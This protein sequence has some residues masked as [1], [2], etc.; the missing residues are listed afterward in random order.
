MASGEAMAT[1]RLSAEM[2]GLVLIRDL[3][4][5]SC[6]RAENVDALPAQHL[7]PD[8]KWSANRLNPA[9]LAKFIAEPH[10]T[11]PGTNMP[12]LFGKLDANAK[13]SAA[14]SIVH[15][16]VSIS[17]NEFE[18]S[19]ADPDTG[20]TENGR[21][22][23]HS[24][25]CVA[26]HSPRD[27]NAN[28][29]ELDGS[30][31]MGDLSAKYDS[32]S[33]VEFL[34]N[35]QVARPHGRMPSLQLSHREAI[36][37][38]TYLLAGSN[39]NQQ[40]VA[41]KFVVAADLASQGKKLFQQYNCSACH[42][43]VLESPSA[44]NNIPEL[45][46]LNL[47]RGC[48]SSTSGSWPKFELS[49][50]EIGQIRSAITSNK[51]NLNAQDE[52]DFTLASY[53]CTSCHSRNQLG[54]VSDLRQ[55]HFQTTNLNLGEQGRIPPTLTGVGSK[56]KKKWMR[57]V[58]VNGR[59]V[60]PY[61]KTRMPQYGESHVAHLVDLF[62]SADQLPATQFV[63][64]ADPREARKAGLQIV[65]NRGLNCAACHTFQY[66][67]SDTMPAVDLTEMAQR[68]KKDW[69]YQYMLDPQKFSPNT[70]MPSYWPGGKALRA[71]IAG[72]PEEQIESVWQYLLEGRQ[73]RPPAGVI[74]EPLEIVVTDKAR[75]L[76]RKYPQIGKR[77]IGVG[78]PGGVNLAYD[79]QQM[80]L[81]TIWR[82]RF[83]DPAAAWY[84]QG[85]GDVRAMGPS[86]QFAKGPELFDPGLPIVLDDARPT[87]HQCKGYSLDEKHRPT[88]RYELGPVVVSDFFREFRDN[89]T[90][91]MQLRRTV[92]ISSSEETKQ[93][94]FRIAA[95]DA[96]TQVSSSTY[97]IGKGLTIKI[98]S[99]RVPEFD[100]ESL[101]YLPLLV[102]PNQTEAIVLEYIWK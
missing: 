1:R 15:F 83:A 21:Q 36:D 91:Q 95:G 73:A 37:L 3:N 55:V 32:R 84:G 42:E 8:L 29:Q 49:D 96:I 4:C 56:L 30:V 85:S 40:R 90:G 66:K 54:G 57:D 87:S 18:D 34:E 33:L 101:L 35:P 51:S 86:I 9:Y 46:M 20:D 74:R 27:A 69:F 5:N 62:E 38:S 80:R 77:G 93:L 24:V 67:L 65:G 60:R 68:L 71:D 25:G 76:R 102:Q 81:A 6:H 14:E 45:A 64:L 43:G 88:M 58:L 82:G 16:L 100:G 7:G 19:S 28:E 39:Q 61:M 26:C 97:N 41:K 75:I 89:E 53:R 79:A 12:E 44:S 22:I 52:I 78:Y 94:R 2:S 98:V 17:G 48:L 13:A 11:K 10:Q 63:E 59:A 92:S 23:F 99:G 31:P 72:T 47:N 50:Q 70:V